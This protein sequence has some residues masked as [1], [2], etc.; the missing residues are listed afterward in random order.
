M[1]NFVTISIGGERFETTR[2]TL[3]G[4]SYFAAMLD[5]E[6]QGLP[7]PRDGVWRVDR[8]A[9]P[10]FPLVLEFLRESLENLMWPDSVFE[11]EELLRAIQADAAY[12][13]IITLEHFVLQLLTIN[14]A[15][16]YLVV[17]NTSYLKWRTQMN[18]DY[19]IGICEQAAKEYFPS[20][21]TLASEAPFFLTTP[22]NFRRPVD[23]QPHQNWWNC[24]KGKSEWP[25][26]SDG[27]FVRW[28]GFKYWGSSSM[29]DDQHGL[30]DPVRYLDC[31]RGTVFH[32][33]LQFGSS[34]IPF[35]APSRFASYL[36]APIPLSKA[37]R[38]VQAKFKACEE[39]RVA[40]VDVPWKII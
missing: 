26:A 17:D 39:F 11:N 9:Q 36:G 16:G 28:K 19:S 18:E 24:G 6:S 14:G 31:V 20:L 30:P 12:Y 22:Q 25:L 23:S 34:R 40:C 8:A 4:S 27:L 33:A 32:F 35:R 7:V 21:H 1:D 5:S 2:T 10:A 13:G 29:N 3:S 15:F 37:F 38:E